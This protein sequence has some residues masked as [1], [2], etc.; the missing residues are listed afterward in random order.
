MKLLIIASEQMVTKGIK[1]RIEDDVNYIFAGGIGSL[2]DH[3]ILSALEHF[4][5]W[6]NGILTGFEIARYLDQIIVRPR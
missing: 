1:E 4:Y 3:E 6:P 2:Q 5:A